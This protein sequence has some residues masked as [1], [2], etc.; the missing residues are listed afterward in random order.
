MDVNKIKE[1]IILRDLLDWYEETRPSLGDLENELNYHNYDLTTDDFLK[2]FNERPN[3]IR[4]GQL[5]EEKRQTEL[6][7]F[8]L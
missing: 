1:V 7:S 2:I 6:F 4:L 5:L 8:I 3:R